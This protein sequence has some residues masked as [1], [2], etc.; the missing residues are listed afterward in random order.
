[1]TKLVL[2]VLLWSATHF[3][4]AVAVDFRKK[5]IDR[6]GEKSYKGF[7]VMLMALAIFLIISG[8]SDTPPE[9]L[10][11]PLAWGKHAASLLVLIAFVLFSASHGQNNIKRFVRHPQLTSVVVWGIAHL[12]ANGESR[13]IVLFGGLALWAAIDIVLLNR[14]DGA[15]DKPAPAP[16][17]K[18]IIAIV[19][20]VIVYLVVANL[21]QWLFGFSPFA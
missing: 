14:R 9:F 19:A 12:L 13:S 15:W 16:M 6:F 20:G 10:Y 8:W 5:M 21:H 17:K 18:D 7:F 1:M 4:P 2:G 11:A 3:I